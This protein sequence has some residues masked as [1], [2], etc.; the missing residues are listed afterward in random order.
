VDPITHLA[1]SATMARAGLKRASPLAS[2]AVVLAGTVPDIDVVGVV[3]GPRAYLALHRTFTHSIPG[4]TAIAVLVAWLLWRLGRK[5]EI[6]PARFGGLLIAAACGAA[7][8]LLLDLGDNY[9][10]KL[11]WPFQSKWYALNLWP[12]L[13]PWLL[14]MLAVVLGVPWLLAIV[15]EEMGAQ[16]K[17]GA[18]VSGIAA[19]ALVAIYC[20]WRAKLHSEAVTELYSST[21]HGALALNVEAFPTPMSPYNWRGVVD[22]YNSIDV[23]QVELGAHSYFDPDMALTHFKLEQSPELKAAEAAPGVAA[24]RSFARFP[25]A[26]LERT[27][28]GH[29]VS[30]RDLRYERSGRFWLNPTVAVELDKNGKVTK[31]NWRFGVPE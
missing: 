29:E 10:E 24:W 25:V 11:F 30:F 2:T 17:R 27:E 7:G 31:V 23:V 28:T 18:S 20:G 19:L 9:G 3:A 12:Q 5:R 8:H 13:D 22:T 6:E 26:D 21:Y 4:A 1:V 16:P 14:L 15:G